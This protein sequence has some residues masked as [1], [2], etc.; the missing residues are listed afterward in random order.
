MKMIKSSILYHN[1]GKKPD[2]INILT[3]KVGTKY[4]AVYVNKLYNS[5]KRNTTVDF[6]FFCYTEDPTD[7]GPNI[8]VIPLEDPAELKLQWHKLKFHNTGF[9]GISTGETCLIL[10]IDWIITNNMDDILSFK[11][12]PGVF[13]CFERWWSNRRN[14]CKINGGFQMYLMGDTQHLY[15]TFF[16]KPTYWQDYYISI[17]EAEGP[18]NGEQNFIDKHVG[19]KRH[20]FPMS[21]FAK[22]RA[23]EYKKIQLNWHLDVNSDEPYYMGGNFADSIKMVHFSNSANQMHLIDES[24]INDYWY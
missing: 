24:W 1:D 17:G 15:D 19:D 12:E 22:V 5:I 20:W 13:G 16:E 11:L 10:D 18:V 9:A 8:N 6:K 23:E 2:I 3:L 4:P 14:W 21:W 7:L